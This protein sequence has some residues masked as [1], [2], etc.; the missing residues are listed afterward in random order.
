MRS[1][2]ALGK[3]DLSDNIIL[4]NLDFE[5]R[6]DGHRIL[7]TFNSSRQNWIENVNFNITLSYDRK[8]DGYDGVWKFIWINIPYP[9]NPDRKN[10]D[11]SPDYITISYCRFTNKF[12][13]FTYGTQN[14][15][16]TRDRTNLLYN[17]W[18]KMLED[19]L[20]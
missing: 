8:G 20:N 18:T 19:F 16:A 17:W 1:N 6:D 5:A 7:L 3:D 14:N 10:L 12:W 15:E 11:R 9:D 13:C 2:D 4:R